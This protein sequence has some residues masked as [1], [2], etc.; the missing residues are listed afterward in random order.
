MANLT[1]IEP[2]T[3]VHDIHQ[4]VALY[5]T[6]QPLPPASIAEH[7][8]DA[9]SQQFLIDQ[10]IANP[11]TIA[12]PPAADYQKKFWKSVV[13]VLEEK[14]VEIEEAIYERLICTLNVP[15]RQG[16]PEA[17]YLTYLLSRP[18][19]RTISTATWRRPPA[20]DNFSQD[21]RPLTIRESRTTIER[22]TTGLRTWRAGLDLSE[23]IL[24]NYHII[25]SAR[26]L[27]LGSGVGLLGL[28]VATLQQLAR[29]ADVK[30]TSC[31][32]MTDVDDDVLARCTSNVRLPCN[33]LADSPN[34]HVRALDWEDSVNVDRQMFMWSLLKE[35]DADV[36]LAADVVYDLSIIPPL[37]HTLRLALERPLPAKQGANN[38]QPLELGL[39]RTAYIALTLRREQTFAEFLASAERAGL[40]V[41]FIEMD[42][43]PHNE[44]VFRGSDDSTSGATD[45]TRLMRLVARG[46]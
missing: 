30:Q 44:R 16:P 4:A 21:Y 31:I 26:V 14:G 39:Q 28:L 9:Q 33:M 20:V 46:A 3:K 34:V 41:E 32:Y 35:I 38:P 23:W 19:S 7:V 25:A 45:T 40:V 1:Q 24:Q 18:K 5:L 15:V 13:I 22:G 6:L 2:W 8:H 42:L 12:Y 43:P 29:P 11:H 36:I 37:T 17:S 10:L 27:E